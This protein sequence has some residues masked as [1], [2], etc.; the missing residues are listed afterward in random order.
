MHSTRSLVNALAKTGCRNASR[1][2]STSVPMAAA[3][4]VKKLG[5]LGAG[6]MVSLASLYD[7]A[8]FYE[9]LL[10]CLYESI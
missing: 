1:S 8:L 9:K 4:E 6:Q 7:L 2:F 10:P 3:A 5:V